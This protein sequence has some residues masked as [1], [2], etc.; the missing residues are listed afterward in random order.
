[1]P[2]DSTTCT[3]SKWRLAS[4]FFPVL[5]FCTWVLG[6]PEHRPWLS[7]LLLIHIEDTESRCAFGNSVLSPK[8]LGTLWKEP[9]L[10]FVTFPAIVPSSP[11][12]SL[13]EQNMWFHYLCFFLPQLKTLWTLLQEVN[14]PSASSLPPLP[15]SLSFYGRS[16]LV[17]LDSVVTLLTILSL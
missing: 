5:L 11:P 9:K 12:T 14:P 8:S 2:Q 17:G 15:S 4:S 6:S 16:I 3:L 13:V 1:M 7:S 10:H